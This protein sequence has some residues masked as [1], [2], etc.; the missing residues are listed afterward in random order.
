MAGINKAIILGNLGRDPEIR[1]LNSGGSC[2]TLSVATSESWKDRNSG[3]K[4]EKTEWHRVV[5]WPEQLV[6]LVEQYVRKGDRIYI[7][8]QIE[9]RKWT[10][11]QGQE[12]YLTEI[13]VRPFGGRIELLGDRRGANGAGDRRDDRDD[14]YQDARSTSR[15]LSGASAGNGQRPASGRGSDLDDEI[16]F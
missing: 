15:P 7:E 4:K 13:V 8:G 6:S 12:R 3:E 14:G 2:A 1:S 10:D 9:T 16:P 11:Q 5:V